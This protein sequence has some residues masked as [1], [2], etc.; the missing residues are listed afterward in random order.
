MTGE[1]SHGFGALP[2]VGAGKYD[3]DM[4]D[5]AFTID[6]FE[7]EHVWTAR[8]YGSRWNGW[9]TPVVDKGTLEAVVAATEEETLRYVDEVAIV[10]SETR[11]KPDVDGNYD[12]GELGWCFVRVD[13]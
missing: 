7:P 8:R 12:L 3:P 1:P 10:S 11:L 5:S 13:G 9:E 4:P 6:G 2:T